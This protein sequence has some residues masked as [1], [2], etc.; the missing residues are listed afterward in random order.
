[1]S[2]ISSLAPGAI[3]R[4]A[5]S[6]RKA[7]LREPRPSHLR[8]PFSPLPLRPSSS[9]SP[10]LL[11]DGCG[12]YSAFAFPPVPSADCNATALEIINH[13]QPSILLHP[14]DDPGTI[15]FLY[16]YRPSLHSS[17]KRVL[18]ALAFRYHNRLRSVTRAIVIKDVLCFKSKVNR[19]DA[20]LDGHSRYTRAT[21]LPVEAS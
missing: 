8:F 7:H 18:A 19:P 10:S 9:V 5:S 20:C 16:P 3:P 13:A 6:S 15:R 21:S 14:A 4:R 17:L 12:R 1:M 11:S 2:S